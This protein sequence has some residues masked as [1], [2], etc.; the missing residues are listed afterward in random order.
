MFHSVESTVIVVAAAI[1]DTTG[2][3]KNSIKMQAIWKKENIKVESV[4][5]SFLAIS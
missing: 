3:S 2:S 4:C 1:I 5:Q